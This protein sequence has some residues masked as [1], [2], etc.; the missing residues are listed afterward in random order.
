MKPTMLIEGL[1]TKPKPAQLWL[2]QQGSNAQAQTSIPLAKTGRT[3][4]GRT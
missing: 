2:T 3:P 4:V 1:C